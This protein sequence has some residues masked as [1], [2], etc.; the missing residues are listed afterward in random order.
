LLNVPPG[1]IVADPNRKEME[2]EV[3][4]GFLEKCIPMGQPCAADDG[5]RE[6]PHV[7]SA[8]RLGEY[9]A[10]QASLSGLAHHFQGGFPRVS[11]NRL[12][13]RPLRYA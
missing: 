4:R 13:L 6:V 7:T 9:S 1:Y 8:N 12:K 11:R 3:L 2:G 5:A 10:I